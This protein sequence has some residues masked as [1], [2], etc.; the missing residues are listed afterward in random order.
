MKNTQTVKTNLKVEDIHYWGTGDFRLP[1]NKVYTLVIDYPFES[2]RRYQI[3]TGGGMG[4]VNLFKHI[5]SAYN[6]TYADADKGNNGYWHAVEDLYIE[7]IK[8]NHK[9]KLITL[10]VGS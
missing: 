5:G 8:V 4:L 6:R 3:K 9:K 2:E 7:E 10:S 1:A